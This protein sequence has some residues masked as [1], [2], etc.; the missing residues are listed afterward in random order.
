[1]KFK[2]KDGLP[3]VTVSLA[4]N[5]QTIQIEEVLIDTG[6]GGTIFSADLLSQIGIKLEANDPIHRI[7]GVGGSEFVYSKEVQRLSIGSLNLDKF[8]IEVGAMDYGFTI[9][10]II[11]TDFLTQVEAVIDF[12]NREIINQAT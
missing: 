9:N 2:I 7:R 3:F 8:E 1:M 11:G 10:G 12:K 4:Y 6:S 5:D